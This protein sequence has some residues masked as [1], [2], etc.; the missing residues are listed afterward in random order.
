MRPTSKHSTGQLIIRSLQ[1]TGWGAF[2]YFIIAFLLVST[3]VVL[4]SVSVGTALPGI[5]DG[6]WAIAYT[7]HVVQPLTEL[8]SS[9]TLN[10]L[11]VAM[12]WGLAGFAVYIGFEYVVHWSKSLRESRTNIRMARGNII[13]HPMAESFWTSVV[14]RAGVLVLAIIFLAAVQPLIRNALDATQEILLTSHLLRDGLRV[15]LAVAEWMVVLHGLV[16]L[17]RL[18]TMRTRLFGDDELY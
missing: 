18:Y 6:Q 15:V 8:L 17:M 5:L 7:E 13:E 9:N 11:L 3:N 4:Q 16:V 1:I 10:K 12:L 2:L 14:W